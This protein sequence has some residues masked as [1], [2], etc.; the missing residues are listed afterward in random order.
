MAKCAD[1]VQN[2]LDAKQLR[3]VEAMPLCEYAPISI[4]GSGAL[5]FLDFARDPVPSLS[6]CTRSS[7]SNGD[8][9]AVASSKISESS[10]CY[11]ARCQVQELTK[12]RDFT[13]NTH[14]RLSK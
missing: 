11:K 10:E 5:R 7:Q 9:S 14:S 1:I 6:G 12:D 2:M 8:V 3:V 13:R 4:S